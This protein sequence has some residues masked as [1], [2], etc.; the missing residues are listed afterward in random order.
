MRYQLNRP[1][2]IQETVDG[3][4]LII[5]TPSGCYYSLEGTGEHLWNALLAG[6]SSA[7][8]AAA[9]PSAG[10]G[11]AAALNDAVELFAR[12]LQAEQLLLPCDLTAAPGPITP[13]AHPFVNPVLQKFTDMQELLLVDPIHEVDPQAG[14]PQRQNLE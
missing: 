14:W 6:Y 10:E 9:Y 8:I 4:A 12:Q 7:E 1:D 11:T 13:A 2:V 5:H 3:E